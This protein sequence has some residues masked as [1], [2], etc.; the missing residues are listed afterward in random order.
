MKLKMTINKIKSI[1]HLEIYLP[2]EKGLY[3]ITGQNGAGKSTL[4]TCASSVFFNMPMKDYFGETEEDAFIKFS[5]GDATRSW[6]KDNGKWN[7]FSEGK[8]SLKGFYE[9]SIIFGNRFKNTDYKIL[10][11]LDKIGNKK[12]EIVDDFVKGYQ[13]RRKASMMEGFDEEETQKKYDAVSLNWNT[14]DTIN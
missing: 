1:N 4:V 6:N 2:I 10:K 9:G 7:K 13:E 8:M 11:S 5:L 3:A 14:K 12:L